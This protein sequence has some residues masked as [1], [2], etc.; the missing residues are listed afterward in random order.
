MFPY[1]GL[2]G[3]EIGLYS[4]M[5]LCGVL[6]AGVYACRITIKQ[7]YDYSEIVI[8]MLILS[9][10]AIITSYLFYVLIN[11]KNIVY[12]IK[13][14]KQIDSF[15]KMLTALRYIFG[16]TIFYGGLL[17]G[18][19]TGYIL[20]KKNRNNNKFVDIVAVNIPLFHSFGR[21]GCFLGGCCFGIP[22]KIGF[23]YT[24]NPIAEANGITRFPVQLLEAIFNF[25][26]FLLLIYFYKNK[27]F[28][29]KLIYV[30]LLVYATGRF[31]IEFFRGDAYRGIWL[32]L[33]TSQIIS[34]LIIMVNLFKVIY[35]KR[36]LNILKPSRN[37]T[38]VAHSI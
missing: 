7:G 36:K 38:E 15:N 21:I 31:F 20:I 30:Y 10:G 29:N 32:F 2:F 12:L 16:G 4:L 23:R 8:F 25:I 37:T 28:R 18:L 13:N 9:V 34:I 24:I 17:G 26:L 27:K 6:S 35:E 33:S 19:L 22:S 5:L 3:R 11:Y 14:I 1:I